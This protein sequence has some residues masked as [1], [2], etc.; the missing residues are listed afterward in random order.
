MCLGNLRILIFFCFATFPV[1]K[2]KTINHLTLDSLHVNQFYK[3]DTEHA[4]CGTDGASMASHS[5]ASL[6]SS[7]QIALGDLLLP[8]W[9]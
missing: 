1:P 5:S 8:H 9:L 6:D 7:H 4:T 3:Y 2:C